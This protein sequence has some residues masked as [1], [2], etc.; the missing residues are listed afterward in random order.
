MARKTAT[1]TID[2]GRDA[3]KAFLL[4]EMPASQAE[5][6]A[7]RAFLAIAKSGKNAIKDALQFDFENADWQ[8][9]ASI[10]EVAAIGFNIF[11]AMDYDLAE[12]LLN[13]MFN[14]VS[15]IPDPT[16]PNVVRALIEDDIEDIST[17]LLL[18]KEIFKLHV[19]FFTSAAA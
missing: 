17:R 19:D 14:C 13:E 10:A 4:K 5:R 15:I 6:W 7:T 2:T 1:I 18:R 9:K 16:R 11:G 3:G 12:P 8:S